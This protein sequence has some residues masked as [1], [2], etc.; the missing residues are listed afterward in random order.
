MCTVHDVHAGRHMRSFGW[1]APRS[2][3]PSSSRL[4][5]LPRWCQASWNSHKM[6]RLSYWK[7][8]SEIEH[9]W[10]FMVSEIEHVWIFMVS[11]IEHVWIF[12]PTHSKYSMLPAYHCTNQCGYCVVVFDSWQGPKYWTCHQRIHPVCETPS[13]SHSVGNG[14]LFPWG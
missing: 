10:I 8:V 4:S 7:Q 3:P 14:G 6:I 2:W 13:V 12:L 5:N 11:E 1:N 9:V